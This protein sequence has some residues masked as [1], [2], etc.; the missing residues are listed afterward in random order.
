MKIIVP[1]VI[2]NLVLSSSNITEDDYSAW[3]NTTTYAVGDRVIFVAASAPV[4]TLNYSAS[5]PLSVG[6]TQ[7][8]PPVGTPATFTTTGTLPSG[9]VVGQIYYLLQ[10][11]DTT[12]FRVSLTPN[13]VPIYVSGSNSGTCSCRF[14][15]HKIYESVQDG[16][17]A[18]PVFLST[19]VNTAWWLEVGST[20]RWKMFDESV[21][22]QSSRADSIVVDLLVAET[23]DTAAFLNVSA[24]TIRL[25]MTNT[26]SVVVYDQTYS[27]AITGGI[28]DRAAD[29]LVS[30]LPNSPGA[31][32]TITLTDTGKQVLCGA[33]ILGNALDIGG[34]QYGATIGIQ[35]FSVKTQDAFGNFS[36]L[37][38]SYSKKASYA[39]SVD[40]TKVDQLQQLLASRRSRATLYIGSASYTSTIILG[41]FK[42]FFEVISYPQFSIC[43]ID[44]EGLI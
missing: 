16:N 9:L 35:D 22:S 19:G 43:N 39:V 44:I 2:G 37:E 42:D 29:L 20:L 30:D 27:M 13:G 3:S 34:T 41:F 26:S 18:H 40:S 36:I 15:I 38:R 12:S 4:L 31:T 24:S 17:L 21:S 11:P 7:N 25:V 32:L 5:S 28:L 14:F 23:I 1:K 33:V 10:G 8:I 6:T